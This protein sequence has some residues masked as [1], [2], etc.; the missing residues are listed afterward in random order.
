MPDFDDTDRRLLDRIQ[1][2]FPLCSRPYMALGRDLGLTEDDV[3][4]RITRLRRDRVIRQISAI[5][6][7]RALGYQSS[8]VAMSVDPAREDGAATVINEH[9]GVSHNYRRDHA[10]NLWF[11]IGLPPTS[12]LE[13]TVNR[14]HEMSG[15]EATRLLP[16]LYVFK[17]GV[18]LDMSGRQP[19]DAQS[20]PRYEPSHQPAPDSAAPPDGP[21]IAIIRE[22]QE[23]IATVPA[24]YAA[25]AE[26][27]HTSEPA[28]FEHAARFV[29][30][31]RLRRVAAVLRHRDAGFVA[32]GMA[33]WIAPEDRAIALGKQMA[34]FFAVTHCYLRP[35]F[36]ENWPYNIFTMIHGHTPEEDV[37][38][39]VNAISRATGLVDYSIL[40]STKE[41]RRLA[42]RT[43]TP[44]SMNGSAVTST[45]VALAGVRL[46]PRT[47]RHG[48][49]VGSARRG[50]E[51]VVG[52]RR[53]AS[54][55][56]YKETFLP[57]SQS[58]DTR[59]CTHPV[60]LPCVGD[61]TAG[62]L[63][64]VW[65]NRT[66]SRVGCANSQT[67]ALPPWSSCARADRP[68]TAPRSEL[69]WRVV[70]RR[71][72]LLSQDPCMQPLIVSSGG[73]SRTCAFPSRTAATS[74]VTTACRR[75]EVAGTGG[76]SHL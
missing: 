26:R 3:V 53:A 70:A 67:G 66:R 22:L 12:D 31:G 68:A 21:D 35:T 2:D 18:R 16:A 63:V 8:L 10:Y 32:N 56:G 73:T 19:L 5:F 59:P 36:E 71:R 55:L 28:L 44:L 65:R 72:T 13:T 48:R 9:P 30:T 20:A 69:A 76:N 11:T 7:S 14:L 6:D 23:D 49:S 37:Q 39:V 54:A 50:H 45:R 60:P 27:L 62:T 15:A 41:T 40:Y 52:A 4:A 34:S 17:I 25:M 38:A 57:A 33:V 47:T 51:M 43:T 64:A 29:Q 61:G 42:S 24:P 58:A 1:T 74:A 75:P 46:P